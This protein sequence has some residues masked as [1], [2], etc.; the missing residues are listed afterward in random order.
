[1]TWALSFY[2]SNVCQHIR[3][4]QCHHSATLFRNSAVPHSNVTRQGVHSFSPSAQSSSSKAW[5]IFPGFI[6][7]IDQS[8]NRMFSESPFIR[9]ACMDVYKRDRYEL[10]AQ[11]FSGLLTSW[12][13]SSSQPRLAQWM[14]S[15]SRS[16]GRMP[17]VNLHFYTDYMYLSGFIN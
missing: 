7:T 14:S 6:M 3:Q 13:M 17:Q 11:G 1:M 5:R 15:F 9:I 2:S 12:N 16:F 10:G 8:H 4:R